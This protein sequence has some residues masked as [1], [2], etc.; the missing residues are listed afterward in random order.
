[1]FLTVK[2]RSHGQDLFVTLLLP[3]EAK[4]KKVEIF[5]LVLILACHHSN[6]KEALLYVDVT[7]TKITK[8]TNM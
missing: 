1:M 6:N 2:N 3:T 4:V 5:S 8:S 7:S